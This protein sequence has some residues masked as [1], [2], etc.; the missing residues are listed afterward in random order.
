MTPNT[1]LLI[2]LSFGACIFLLIFH[3]QCAKALYMLF[4][5]FLLFFIHN[6]YKWNQSREIPTLVSS[7]LRE[8][9]LLSHRLRIREP[10][11]GKLSSLVILL[12]PLWT[13]AIKVLVLIIVVRVAL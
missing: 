13:K 2:D 1:F 5:L 8:H 9:H 3:I 12:L 10:T 6:I 4:S 11:L 7:I